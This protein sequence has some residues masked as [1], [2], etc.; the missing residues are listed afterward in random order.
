[1]IENFISICIPTYNREKVIGKAIR[2]AFIQN[3]E[4]FEVVVLDNNSSDN[5]FDIISEIKHE[6][7]RI[8]R[9]DNTVNMYENHNLVVS[10][11][12]FDWVLILHSDEELLPNILFEYNRIINEYQNIGFITPLFDRPVPFA[13]KNESWFS[14]Q[15]SNIKAEALVLNGIGQPSGVCFNREALSRIN[16]FFSDIKNYYYFCDHIT[17]YKIIELNYSFIFCDKNVTV[18]K[19]NDEQETNSLKKHSILSDQIN[20]AKM[21]LD[22]NS[23]DIFDFIN[24]NFKSFNFQRQLNLIRIFLYVSMRG[25]AFKLTRKIDFSKLRLTPFLQ[26]LILNL[27]G[28]RFYLL[29]I[30]RL[31]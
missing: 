17:Y 12:K 1:M 26:L 30:K 22:D 27:L 25:K 4:N 21:V 11:S 8:F 28:T 29:L 2:S 3:Y 10:K 24:A 19:P 23:H 14:F 20:F 18:Y 6:K 16:G 5:S 9:N 7:L 13:L 15:N 31:N